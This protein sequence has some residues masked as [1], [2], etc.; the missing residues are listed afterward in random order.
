MAAQAILHWHSL[1]TQE[2]CYD[3]KLK[4]QRLST[5]AYAPIM[6]WPTVLEGGSCAEQLVSCL[7]DVRGCGTE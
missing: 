6:G 3:G 5:P 1:R 2:R 7:R 4:E